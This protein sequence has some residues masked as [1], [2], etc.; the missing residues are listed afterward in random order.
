MPLNDKLNAAADEALL[1]DAAETEVAELAE[2]EL[3]LAAEV[4]K[5]A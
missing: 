4:L 2:L 1:D 3:P 5:K